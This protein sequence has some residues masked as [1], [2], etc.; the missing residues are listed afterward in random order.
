MPSGNRTPLFN[1]RCRQMPSPWGWAWQRCGPTIGLAIWWRRTSGPFSDRHSDTFS[2]LYAVKLLVFND[3]LWLT[4]VVA[5]AL[6]VGSSAPL[7]LLR[8]WKSTTRHT[9]RCRYRCIKIG[10][11]PLAVD[12]FN[13]EI[14]VFSAAWTR[15]LNNRSAYYLHGLRPKPVIRM[16]T[17]PA[18]GSLAETSH[19]NSH[20]RRSVQMSFARDLHP[21]LTRYLRIPALRLWKRT[22]KV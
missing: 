19:L 2:A 6:A 20:L 5:N 1:P 3:L 13:C 12:S 7:S 16:E 21:N 8:G 15:C 4:L 18:S 9:S 22:F 14:I 10:H 11:V 17:V